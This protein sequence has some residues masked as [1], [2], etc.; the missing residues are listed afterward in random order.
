MIL[1]LLL[2][3][4]NIEPLTYQRMTEYLAPHHPEIDLKQ[5]IKGIKSHSW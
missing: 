4:P 2:P 1:K 5:I 3:F